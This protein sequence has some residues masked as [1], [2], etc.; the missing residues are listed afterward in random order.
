MSVRELQHELLRRK[1]S[2]V[3]FIIDGLT[4]PH[5]AE[6]A[7]CMPQKAD[8]KEIRV[9]ER[10]HPEVDDSFPDEHSACTYAQIM[11]DEDGSRADRPWW[12]R[13]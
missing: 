7:V 10:G 11:A 6:G 13:W 2:G 5:A 1:V 3:A 12:W 4:S 8:N 9:E